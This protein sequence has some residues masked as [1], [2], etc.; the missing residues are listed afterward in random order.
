MTSERDDYMRRQEIDHDLIR[1]R[2]PQY[3]YLRQQ[4]GR[5]LRPPLPVTPEVLAWGLPSPHV[6]FETRFP[7]PRVH[8]A[9]LELDDPCD[10]WPVGRV[11]KLDGT[12]EWYLP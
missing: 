8:Q 7:S 4:F 12:S 11:C 3:R 1:Q 5:A 9:L 10:D 6:E 2:D